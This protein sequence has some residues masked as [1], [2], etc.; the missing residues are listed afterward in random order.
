VSV[1]CERLCWTVGACPDPARPK[2]AQ[3]ESAIAA[4]FGLARVG[5]SPQSTQHARTKLLVPAPPANDHRS[6]LD[7]EVRRRTQVT[8]AATIRGA[9]KQS[10]HAVR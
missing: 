8:G 10:E 3:R 6:K 9:T 4:D 5:F 7:G 1:R 2:E